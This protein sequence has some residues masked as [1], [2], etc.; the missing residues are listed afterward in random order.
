MT[1]KS[2]TKLTYVSTTPISK[3][4]KTSQDASGL[5]TG[6]AWDSQLGIVLVSDEKT[7]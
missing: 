5:P 7:K 3:A 6:F 4:T 2:N 1:E